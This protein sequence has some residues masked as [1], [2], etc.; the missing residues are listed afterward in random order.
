MLRDLYN[1]YRSAT[2]R[3]FWWWDREERINIAAEFEKMVC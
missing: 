3:R 1:W 2:F